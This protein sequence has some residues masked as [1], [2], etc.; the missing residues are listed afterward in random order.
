M[1]LLMVLV[2]GGVLQPPVTSAQ[3]VKVSSLEGE[4]SRDLRE[5]GQLLLTDA[6]KSSSS[7]DKAQ[8]QYRQS[9]QATAKLRDQELDSRVLA[10][11]QDAKA[12]IEQK[13]TNRF[14]YNRQLIS[15]SILN[16]AYLEVIDALEDGDVKRANLWFQLR[17]RR[18]KYALKADP[19]LKAMVSLEKDPGRLAELKPTIEKDLVDTYF[20]LFKTSLKTLNEALEGK[21]VDSRK[22]IESSAQLLGYYYIIDEDLQAKAG[23]EASTELKNHLLS[24]TNSFFADGEVEAVKPKITEIKSL[25]GKFGGVE[26]PALLK[27]KASKIIMLLGYI[28]KNYPAAVKEGKVFD[29]VEYRELVMFAKEAQDRLLEIESSLLAKGKQGE[30]LNPALTEIRIGLQ[31]KIP[32]KELQALVGETNSTL[33]E[34]TGVTTVESKSSSKGKDYSVIVTEVKDAMKK[35]LTAY[36]EGDQASTADMAFNAY[37]IFEPMEEPLAVKDQALVKKLEADFAGLRGAI[38]GRATAA[39]VET[40][41]QELE[42]DL[43]SALQLLEAKDTNYSV[44][45]QSLTIILREGLEAIIIIGALA[46]YVLRTGTKKQVMV[47]YA[48]AGAAVI[49]SFLT[50]WLVENVFHLTGA[51]QEVMEGATMLFAVAVLFYVSYWLFSKVEGKRWQQFIQSKLSESVGSGNLWAMAT[52][53]FLSVY[54]EGVETILF[55]KALG[56]LSGGFQGAVTLGFLLGCGILAIV[57]LLFNRFGVR[58]PIKTFFTFTGVILYYMA[59][60]FAGHGIAELQEGGAVSLTPASFIPKVG[61]LGIYPTWETTI[62]QVVLILAQLGALAYLFLIKPKSKKE[63]KLQNS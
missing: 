5:A 19:A 48:G 53:A 8:Q 31:D 23:A 28:E 38:E 6:V 61:F 41:I 49:G 54:R 18:Y 30:G 20:F 35:L 39:V 57:F 60:S 46:T 27:S 14:N 32:V 10:A 63:A 47:I 3:E 26:D 51:G 42:Q 24:V 12:A 4:I 1:A 55:Y 56:S 50:A 17:E 52:V 2:L 44:F 45:F 37:F 16:L 9:F 33:Q 22:A 36:K 11:F 25:L 13:D 29:P 34:L 7:L 62:L 43:D 21:E 15:K 59:F 40:R 58:I